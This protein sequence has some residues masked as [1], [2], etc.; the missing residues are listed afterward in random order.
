MLWCV[1]DLVVVGWPP[2]MI[3]QKPQ[4]EELDGGAEEF[5]KGA[6]SNQV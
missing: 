4:N 2:D 1:D 3:S 5:K 6:G